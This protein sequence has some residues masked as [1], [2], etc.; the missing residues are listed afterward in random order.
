MSHIDANTFG[1]SG[2]HIFAGI[3]D[4]FMYLFHAFEVDFNSF[5]DGSFHLSL[6]AAGRF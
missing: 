4:C 2:S 1:H 6:V 3:L 5:L